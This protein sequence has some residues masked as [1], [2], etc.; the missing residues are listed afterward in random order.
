MSAY[1]FT[2]V[3]DQT[4]STLLMESCTAL[5]QAKHVFTA[6]QAAQWIKSKNS[7]KKARY[8]LLR[9]KNGAEVVN[10][11]E[12]V[13]S[14]NL[15]SVHITQEASTNICGISDLDSAQGY[16]GNSHTLFTG[17]EKGSEKN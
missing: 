2:H 5:E 15:H 6:R 14:L 7:N 8:P 9:Q 10:V 1:Y 12:I 3:Q 16:T 17:N 4:V 13:A 11:Y